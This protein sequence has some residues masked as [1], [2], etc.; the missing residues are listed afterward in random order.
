M[1]GWTLQ[2]ESQNIFSGDYRTKVRV[3]N[4]WSCFLVLLPAR[5]RM[6]SRTLRASPHPR[7]PPQDHFLAGLG[8]G[9]Q[10]PGFL[11]S[12]CSWRLRHRPQHRSYWSSRCCPT[13]QSWS[14]WRSPQPAACPAAGCQE[15][16]RWLHETRQKAL[17]GR[18][19]S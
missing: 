10:E 15:E 3:S 8:G 7:S 6:D 14:T 17:E 9:G 2:E 4:V 12:H 1:M 19:N 13:S 11:H 18:K 16:P 5:R